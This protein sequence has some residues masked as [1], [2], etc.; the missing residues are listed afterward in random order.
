[1]SYVLLSEHSQQLFTSASLTVIDLTATVNLTDITVLTTQT[2]KYNLAA[3]PS[4]L[5]ELRQFITIDFDSRTSF[6]AADALDFEPQ[7]YWIGA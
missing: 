6:N 7:Q 3:A 1:M 4:V 5:L 2:G